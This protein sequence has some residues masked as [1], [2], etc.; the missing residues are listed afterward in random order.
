M[1]MCSKQR[2]VGMML[3]G[4]VGVGGCFSEP[5]STDA[6]SGT[7]GSGTTAGGTTEVSVET[8]ESGSTGL[9]SQGT[10]ATGGS[11]SGSSG[12]GTSGFTGGSSST[13][14][15]PTGTSTTTGGDVGLCPD[16]FDSFDANVVGPAW[17]SE[18]PASLE[19]VGGA[20]VITLTPEPNDIYP[21]RMIPWSSLGVE[22]GSS[23]SFSVQPVAA[24]TS[25]GTQFNLVLEGAAGGNDV[26]FSLNNPPAG[27]QYRITT[28]DDGQVDVLLEQPAVFPPGGSLHAVVGRSQIRFEVFDAKGVPV[29]EL[30]ST[31]IP[32]DI[33]TSR[34]G[35]AANNYFQL[36]GPE[37]L[38]AE[39][40][41]IV[42]D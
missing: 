2:V 20:T 26:T 4:V 35:F 38:S 6:T 3:V 24:P 40:F 7:S 15:G 34:I 9:D 17:E 23:V 22:A 33:E 21:R 16:F 25:T 19:Q 42:C 5:A 10:L 11:S 31:R 8:T 13:S 29:D 1:S 37:Q 18:H 32:F 39:S 30:L 14:A 41:S 28:N 27:L 12:T 36:A